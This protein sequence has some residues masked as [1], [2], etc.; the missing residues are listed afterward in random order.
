M[1]I[2][3]LESAGG[4]ATGFLP[5][6]FAAL[7]MV[8]ASVWI[9]SLAVFLCGRISHADDDLPKKKPAAETTRMP[10]NVAPPKAM[11][12][13]R[14]GSTMVD[15]TGMYGAASVSG[16]AAGGSHG[17]GGGGGD[18]GG[19]DDLP[20]KKPA[21]EKTSRPAS[22][23]PVTARSSAGSGSTMVDPTGIYGA[24]YVSGVA[25]GGGGCGGGGGGGGDGDLPMQKPA[26][27][28]TSIPASV[29]PAKPRSLA[30]SGS[31]VVDPTGM[32]GAS[33]VSGGFHGHGGGG[34]C[35]GGGGGG[36]LPRKKLTAAKTSMPAS[37]A[38][39]KARSSATSGSTMVE[40]TGMYVSG[41]DAGGCHGHDGGGGYGGGGG[42]GGGGG[43]GGGCGGC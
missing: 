3:L 1:A 19:G 5:P 4:A 37:V 15:P 28:K 33:Y 39:A 42:C 22:V 17:H 30:R 35:G 2:A 38:P 6:W 16:V 7:G 40:P 32:Y 43:G 18:G 34:G 11:S 23:T 21:E 26:A 36:D 31:T 10:I 14:S 12:P 25:T 9:V 13:S 24:A 8:V 20:R 41:V 29:A 27:A